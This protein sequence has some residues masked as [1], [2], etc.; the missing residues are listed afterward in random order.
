MAGDTQGRRP[1]LAGHR[2]T[3]LRLCVRP[4]DQEPGADG[5]SQAQQDANND[6]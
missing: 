6:T 3:R 4:Q 1:R 5:D 2:I